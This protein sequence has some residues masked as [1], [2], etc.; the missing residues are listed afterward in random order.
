MRTVEPFGIRSTASLNALTGAET[1]SGSPA[2]NTSGPATS[3]PMIRNSQRR[4][5]FS[6]P[7]VQDMGSVLPAQVAALDAEDH[8]QPGRHHAQRGADQ[9]RALGRILG[10]VHDP[11]LD[12]AE[13]ERVRRPRDPL[14]L[15]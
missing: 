11:F 2:G 14:Q 5:S 4:S 9:D 13:M 10:N 15:E 12:G 8:A 3:S 7:E 1:E 6:R